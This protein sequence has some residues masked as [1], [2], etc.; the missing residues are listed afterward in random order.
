MIVYFVSKIIFSRIETLL[1]LQI[2]NQ[3][4][5]LMALFSVFDLF[6]SLEQVFKK[7]PEK[8]NLVVKHISNITLQIYIVQFVIIRYCD[9]LSFPLNLIVV[10]L[11]IIVVATLLYYIENRIRKLIDFL[12]AKSRK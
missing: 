5:I 12:C 8:L 6:M 4:V 2:A 10:I 1:P 9:K 11:A 3:F 7:M